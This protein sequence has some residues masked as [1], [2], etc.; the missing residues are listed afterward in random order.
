MKSKWLCCWKKKVDDDT[1]SQ[2]TPQ[3][4]RFSNGDGEFVFFNIGGTINI[5]A[6]ETSS[7]DE[8][9]KLKQQMDR[10]EQLLLAQ[11]GSNENKVDSK[12]PTKQSEQIRWPQF[13]T[14]A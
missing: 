13:K 14:F 4:G 10:I 2:Q 11:G 12:D 8:T 3:Q 9:D 6:Q 1:D 7:S 5:E